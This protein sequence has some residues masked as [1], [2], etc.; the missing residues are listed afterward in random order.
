MRDGLYRVETSYFV[1]GFV[2]ENGKPTVIAPILRK[3]FS[4]WKQKAELITK[5]L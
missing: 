5:T 4:Y 2:I 1:A 3:K